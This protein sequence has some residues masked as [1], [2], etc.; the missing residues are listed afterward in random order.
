MSTV[1]PPRI[2]RQ[3]A[4]ELRARLLGDPVV[5]TRL[6]WLAIIGITVVAGLLRFWNLDYPGRL[7]FDET[8]YVKDGW[9]LWQYGYEIKWPDEPNEDFI[10]GN[11][12][13]LD[14]PGY[15][16][17]PPLGKWLIGAGMAIFG[18]DNGYG[19]RFASALAGTLMVPLFA[20]LVTKMFRAQFFGVLGAILL[21]AEGHHMVLSRAGLLDIFLAL[22]VLAAFL[23]LVYDRQWYRARLLDWVERGYIPR[24]PHLLWRPWWLLAA[25]FLGCATSVKLSAI[26]FVGMFCLLTMAWDWQ[27]RRVLFTVGATDAPAL[28]KT[29]QSDWTPALVTAIPLY[30]LTYLATWS[31]WIFTSGGYGRQWSVENPAEGAGRLVPHWLRSLTHYHA[32]STSFHSG[33]E[34]SHNYASTPWT[35]WV[36]GRPTSF[37]YEGTNFGEDGCIHQSCSAAITDLANPLLWWA[38]AVA[39]LVV[40]FLAFGRNDWRAWSVL[41]GYVAGFFIW[42]AFPNRTMFFFY[43]VSYEIFLI[44]GVLLA[45]A[46]LMRSLSNHHLLQTGKY[47]KTATL[48]AIVFVAA[49]VAVSAFFL[50]VWTGQQ[51]DYDAWRA[52]MWFSS[53]I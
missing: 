2:G 9:S 25:V 19:W 51:I 31:G 15:V 24:L 8:Y 21:A 42:L 5:F 36:M 17:H 47:S 10:A 35:W 6:G 46:W 22:F 53:W 34:S 33:L 32:E 11:P 27:A 12:Q 28:P 20:V 16:V 13:P 26:A 44:L 14:A 48:T 50:P 39:F 30:L 7:I 49:V 52:R 43:T 40:L 38:G 41:A 4:A 45:L 18:M 1:P 29:I 37:F 3:R 23:A